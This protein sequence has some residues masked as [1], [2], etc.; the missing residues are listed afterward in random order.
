METDSLCRDRT[1]RRA[2]EREGKRPT[3]AHHKLA[4]AVHAMFLLGDRHSGTAMQQAYGKD[5]D[6]D[7]MALIV[8]VVKVPNKIQD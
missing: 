3:S 5:N 1:R 6:T 8:R 4:M 2:G 7:L